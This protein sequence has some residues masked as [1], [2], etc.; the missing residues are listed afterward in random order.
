MM[1]KKSTKIH[2][3]R[4]HISAQ[5]KRT[6]DRLTVSFNF[7]RYSRDETFL[8]AIYDIETKTPFPKKKMILNGSLIRK[9]LKSVCFRG[10]INHALFARKI[11][12]L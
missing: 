1:Q 10:Y 12:D 3:N 2:E 6:T 11:C 7:Y 4:I 5:V 8:A 9:F